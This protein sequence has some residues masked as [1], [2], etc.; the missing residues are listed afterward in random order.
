MGILFDPIEQTV[1][2]YLSSKGS[3]KNKT[4]SDDK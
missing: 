3:G 1:I 4:I 2:L